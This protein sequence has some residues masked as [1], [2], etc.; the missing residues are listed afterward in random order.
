M[1]RYDGDLCWSA[2]GGP[3]AESFLLHGLRV[4]RIHATGRSISNATTTVSKLFKIL[5][6]LVL[7]I[8]ARVDICG[9]EIASVISAPRQL[10]GRSCA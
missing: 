4:P 7:N 1:A 8:D 6:G 5:D 2:S 3:R 10:F 9:E